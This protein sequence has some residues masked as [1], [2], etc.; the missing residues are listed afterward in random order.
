MA[1]R[2]LHASRQLFDRAY[3]QSKAYDFPIIT[4]MVR[5][6]GAIPATSAPSKRV[7]SAD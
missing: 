7:F 2:A 1:T 3:M 6:Y 5:D 4:Q